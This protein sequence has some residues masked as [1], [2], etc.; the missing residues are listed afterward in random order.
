MFSDLFAAVCGVKRQLVPATLF[1]Y[2][3]YVVRDEAYPAIVAAPTSTT[4]GYLAGSIT[5]PMWQRLDDFETD[6][7]ALEHVTVVCA[8]GR[9]ELAVTYVIAAQ[10]QTALTDCDWCADE[11]SREHLAGYLAAADEL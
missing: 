8:D 9:T 2:A 10:H 5:P 11:F 4:E 3:R 1:G 6:L 7:Y